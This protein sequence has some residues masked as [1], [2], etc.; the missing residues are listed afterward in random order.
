MV[1]NPASLTPTQTRYAIIELEC[2]AIQWAIQKCSYYLLSRNIL[3]VDISQTLGRNISKKHLQTGE[4]PPHENER[5]DHG[6]H[7]ASEMGS[8]QDSLYSRGPVPT[9]KNTQSR[10]TTKVSR[11]PGIPS[12]P[13]V[14]HRNLIN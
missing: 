12:W 6:V 13:E 11:Q 3:S 5:E 4:L 8:W 1:I 9:K 10:V 14:S 2:M 7:T